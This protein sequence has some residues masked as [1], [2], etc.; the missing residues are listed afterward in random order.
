VLS[1]NNTLAYLNTASPPA[2]PAPQAAT[3]PPRRR[4]G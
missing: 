1:R 3:L 2:A 4:E